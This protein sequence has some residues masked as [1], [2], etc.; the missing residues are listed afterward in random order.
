MEVLIG[1]G[2]AALAFYLVI[3]VLVVV[4]AWLYRIGGG[5]D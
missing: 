3:R 2:F 1:F 4:V 5:E